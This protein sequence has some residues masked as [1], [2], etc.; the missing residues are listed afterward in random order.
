[1]KGTP[2]V[3][4]VIPVYNRETYI[5]D[6][7]ESSLA[8]TYENIEIIVVDN[9]STDRT[10]DVLLDYER[11]DS[12]IR[13]FQNDENIGPVLNWKRCFEE[14]KGDYIKVLWSDDWME[15]DFVKKAI[16]L[17]DDETAFVMS[18]IKLV[19]NNRVIGQRGLF[20]FNAISTKSYIDDVLYTREYDFPVSPGCALFR[21]ADIIDVELD[22]V[23]NEE[24]LNSLKNGAGNDLLLF[25]VIA[26]KYSV[27]R[28]INTP[29][30]VFRCH[31]GSFTIQSNLS[32]YYEWARLYFISKYYNN[33]N[34][35]ILKLW[36]RRCYCSTHEESWRCLSEAVPTRGAKIIPLLVLLVK[37]VYKKYISVNN[38]REN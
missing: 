28:I 38:G 6:A 9:K 15:N 35:L 22:A 12:R 5:I 14:A 1:M 37:K 11:K 30:S 7:I 25:L 18:S 19:N 31:E 16:Q 8:Q 2:L 10:M 27:I 32:N 36:Y 13:V 29:L 21:K 34:N 4:I 23:P 24:G 20:P 17:F 26:N 33:K 3:S